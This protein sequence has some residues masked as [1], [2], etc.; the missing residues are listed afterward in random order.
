MTWARTTLAALARHFKSASHHPSIRP[1]H[2]P[3]F[4][5]INKVCAHITLSN[6]NACAR[7]KYFGEVS[8]ASKC[9]SPYVQAGLRR[10][11]LFFNVLQVS[12]RFNGA[13]MVFEEA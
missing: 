12:Q 7:I 5:P 2:L 13:R 9:L 4:N 6:R 10:D 11:T 1:R 3:H 8:Q